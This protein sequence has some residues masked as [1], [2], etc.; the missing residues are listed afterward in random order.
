MNWLQPPEK[1]AERSTPRGRRTVKRIKPGLYG[2]LADTGSLPRDMLKDA[3]SAANETPHQPA[4]VEDAELKAVGSAGEAVIPVEIPPVAPA[5]F[6]AAGTNK[7]QAAHDSPVSELEPADA[8]EPGLSADIAPPVEPPDATAAIAAEPQSAHQSAE[9]IVGT[10]EALSD[11]SIPLPSVEELARRLEDVGSPTL[12]T[13]ADGSVA[14]E[15][16]A[17]PQL[18]QSFYK[19][20]PRIQQPPRIPHLGHLVI[21]IFLAALGLLGS[22][23]LTRSALHFHLWGI[24]TVQNAVTDV[25][26]TVGSMAALYLITFGAALLI[27]PHLWHRGFFSGVQ[28]NGPATL[29]RFWPL[30]TAAFVC[31]ALAM[32]DELLLPGPTNAPIDKLFDTSASAWLLFGFGVTFAP[33]FE[34]IIF[35]GFLLPALCTAWDWAVEES[36][37]KPAPALDANGHPQWS[38]FAMAIGSVATSIPFALMHAEQTA[39]SLG[40]F[41]LLFAV[42][43]VLCWARLSTRS[44]AASVVVH[45]SY[46]FLLFSLMLLGTEGFKHLDKM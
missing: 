43:L 32:V 8:V 22:S 38:I 46:N 31:F 19:T 4:R 27:F 26:Y 1:I 45:A 6:T 14:T 20:K 33:F 13:V 29:I 40:P 15:A 35:R 23:L 28:W 12:L 2:N 17:E 3:R 36:T 34:E 25:H 41:L 37:G 5:N 18:F 7:P 42:S 16:G 11:Q 21:L 24:S 9:E 10:T 39:W 44:L 30:L